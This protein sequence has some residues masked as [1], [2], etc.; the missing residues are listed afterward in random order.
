M[1]VNWDWAGAGVQKWASVVHASRNVHWKINILH[2]LL[3]LRK[4]KKVLK[5][6]N[7]NII[8][9]ALFLNELQKIKSAREMD[10]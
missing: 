8:T 10:M 3:L 4:I 9:T 1:S 5:F 2:L 7:N 6:Y